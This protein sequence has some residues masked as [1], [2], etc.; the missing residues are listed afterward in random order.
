MR[1]GRCYKCCE[2]LLSPKLYVCTRCR[3]LDTGEQAGVPVPVGPREPELRRS[4]ARKP[5]WQEF[6]EIVAAA[7]DGALSSLPVDGA[8]RHDAYLACG[9]VGVAETAVGG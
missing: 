5:I 9:V 4:E 3:E 1:L 6:D 7:P 8:E 2:R